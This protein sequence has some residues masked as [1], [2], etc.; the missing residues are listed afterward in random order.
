MCGIAGLYA[1]GLGEDSRAWVKVLQEL[2]AQSQIR[3]LHAGGA[4]WWKGPAKRGLQSFSQAGP[5]TSLPL[6]LD[7]AYGD[8]RGK[9]G[10]AV[11]LHARYS[12]SDLEFNQPLTD[13]PRLPGVALTHN[14]VVSQEPPAS[15]EALYGLKCEGRNDSELL[16]R[17]FEDGQHPLRGWPSASA[18]VALLTSEGALTLSRNGKRPLYLVTDLTSLLGPEARGVVWGSTLDVLKR[19][20]WPLSSIRRMESGGGWRWAS[21]GSPPQRL[22]P[23]ENSQDLTFQHAGAS[24]PEWPSALI[25]SEPLG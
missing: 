22:S 4:A 15:W 9:K 5:L 12:T 8:E 13:R 16:L 2:M 23:L 21:P 3:G 25:P 19:A 1:E 10:V 20:G 6:P 7:L 14:G 11:L 24:P 18:A 17:S